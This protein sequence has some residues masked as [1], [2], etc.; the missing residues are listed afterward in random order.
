M[1]VGSKDEKR[2]YES[3]VMSNTFINHD[4]Q[5]SRLIYLFEDLFLG[6]ENSSCKA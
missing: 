2:F 1:T 4:I 6:T 5:I 3:G